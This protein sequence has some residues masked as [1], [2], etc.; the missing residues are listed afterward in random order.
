[1]PTEQLPDSEWLQGESWNGFK[2]LVGYLGV[3]YPTCS[4]F[5]S[6]L[7]GDNLSPLFMTLI[8]C[9]SLVITVCMYIHGLDIIHGC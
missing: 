4:L 6:A 7:L 9:F 8:V 1:M 5:A 3:K 2:G